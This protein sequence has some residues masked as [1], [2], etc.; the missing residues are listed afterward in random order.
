LSISQIPASGSVP[1]GGDGVGGGDRGLPVVGVQPVGAAGRGE[2]QQGFT[3][4]VELELP[5]DPVPDQVLS[6]G[7]AG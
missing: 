2:Q 1:P 6:A 5:V 7:I 3:E 4:H